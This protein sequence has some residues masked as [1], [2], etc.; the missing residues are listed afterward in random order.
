MNRRFDAAATRSLAERLIAIPSVSPDPAGETRCGRALVDALPEG[1]ERGAW[2]LRDRREIVWARLRGGA[3]FA[4]RARR[5]VILL[6]HHDTVGVGEYARLGAAEGTLVAFQPHRMREVLEERAADVVGI[7]PE[8]LPALRDALAAGD[9]W[10]FGRGALDMK[11]GLAAAVAALAALAAQRDTLAGDVLFVSCP[12]EEHESAGM[13]AA[14]G[15]ILRLRNT[16]GLDLVGAINLDYTEGPVGYTGVLGKSLLGVYVLG[17]PTHAAASFE[18]ADAAQMA[19]AIVHRVTTSTLLSARADGTPG[20][21]P[22]ALRLRDLKAAYNAQTADEA[23]AEINLMSDGRRAPDALAQVRRVIEDTLEEVASRIEALRPQAGAGPWPGRATRVI[24]VAELAERAGEGREHRKPRHARSR[25]GAPDVREAT[26][27]RV[28]KLARSADLQAPA[29]V[30]YLAPPFHPHV[31]P[32]RGPLS[33]AARAALERAGGTLEREYPFISDASYLAWGAESPEEL[34]RY[35]P[36][37]G[38][39]YTLPA[40]ES[41]ALGLE[42]VTL[43]PWGRDAHGLCERVYAPWAFATLPKLIAEVAREAVAGA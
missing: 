28:R 22:V 26:L 23:V 39:E 42:V 5:M 18:G 29:V 11:S 36:A 30:L 15:E 8:V 9:D 38:L 17:T 34:S 31:P 43:G 3:P 13:L 2:R 37:L 4:G 1:V 12:D 32:G 19:A 25:R 33:R 7:S 40:E 35:L 14:V 16:E 41:R 24:T 10:L 20:P 27:A 21:P 6:G